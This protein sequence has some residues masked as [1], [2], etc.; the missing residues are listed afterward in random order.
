MKESSGN[1]KY[2]RIK[3]DDVNPLTMTSALHLTENAKNGKQAKIEIRAVL[4]KATQALE[5]QLHCNS[6]VSNY[7]AK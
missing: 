1:R 5:G 4:I 3:I 6:A 2:T 7:C